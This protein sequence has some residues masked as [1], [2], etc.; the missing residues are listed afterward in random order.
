MQPSPPPQLKD[1]VLVGAG[2]AHVSVLRMFGMKPM[3]GVRITLISRDMHTPY[4]GMLPGLVAG[5][6]AFDD[7]HID[8]NRLARFCGATLIHAEASGIDLA[9]RQVL[10]EGRPPVPYDVLS[11]DIGSTPQTASVPGAAEHVVPVKPINRFL[12]RW[13]S[14]LERARGRREALRIA[15]VGAG[16]GG[17]ELL[18]AVRHALQERSSELDLPPVSFHIF[19]AGDTILPGMP[20]AVQRKLIRIF[21]ERDVTVHRNQRVVRVHDGALETADGTMHQADEILWVTA[22]GA[23]GWIGKSGLATADDGFMAVGR[24]LQ[25]TSHPDVFGAGDIA[26]MIHDPRPKAGVFA[27]RQGKV[28]ARNL[29]QALLGRPLR[30]HRPQKEFLAIISTGGK[31]AVATRNGLAAEGGWVWRWKDWIDRRFMRRFNELPEMKPA[32]APLLAPELRDI[33]GYDGHAAGAMRCAGC[34]AK[35]GARILRDALNDLDV[36]AR[37]D[38]L[39]GLDQPDDAAII[40][41]P[42]GKLTVQTVDSFRAM[43]SDP[44]VFG[45]IAANHALGDVYAMGAVPQSAMAIATVPHASDRITGDILRQLMAGANK[46]L[47]EAGATLAGGHSAEGMEI[48]LGFAVTGLVDEGKALRK[49][50]LR[51]GDVLIL[52]KPLGTGALF[53][54]DMRGR[55]KGRWIAGA[56]ASMLVPARE[57]ARVFADCGASACTDVTGFGLAGHLLEMLDASGVGAEIDPA[58]LPLLEGV[59]DVL[60]N[61]IVSSLQ[62]QNAGAAA[63]IR[64]LPQGSALPRHRILFDPQTAGGLLAGVPA[65]EAGVCLARLRASGYR[66]AA[67]VGHAGPETSQPEIIAGPA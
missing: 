60:A 1:L 3:S 10:I 59:E 21:S 15:V 54:A 39:A 24:T 28:L 32:L 30:E 52:T 57:A 31:H 67:I 19:S 62:A 42:S 48:A 53:A 49:S 56:V 26:T 41:P 13:E 18:L 7:V 27:V 40:R 47:R 38:V 9:G 51:P 5:H 50:G 58:A 63:R 35:V 6:Y 11:I 43:V 46:V 64:G 34:G 45:Q 65:D 36:L 20:D 16:A 25:S 33:A 44:F 17:T 29:R 12:E 2:H 61:D 8:V 37:D 55:A 66:D 4:S 14:L 23:A 22:A